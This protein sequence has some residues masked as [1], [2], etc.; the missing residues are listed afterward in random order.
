MEWVPMPLNPRKG[1]SARGMKLPAI[2]PPNYESWATHQRG[3][4]W[5]LFWALAS[6]GGYLPFG[7]D[8]WKLSGALTRSRWELNCDAVLSAFEFCGMDALGSSVGASGSRQIFYRPL[9]EIIEA[10]KLKPW[11]RRRSDLE[12]SEVSTRIHR[13]AAKPSISLSLDFDPKE[14]EEEKIAAKSGKQLERERRERESCIEAAK[15]R[16]FFPK[17]KAAMAGD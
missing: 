14:K 8:L 4:F 16:G 6:N 5:N 2:F 9:L 17:V 12:I 3:M 1:S 15:R 11:N 13:G 7:S 10:Q